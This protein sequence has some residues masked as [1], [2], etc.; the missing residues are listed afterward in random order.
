MPLT[1]SSFEGICYA[2]PSEAV[3]AYY[4]ASQPALT[5]GATSYLTEF[6]K[7][8]GIWRAK[9]WS[10][11]TTGVSTLRWNV[12]A[13]VPTFEPCDPAQNFLDGMELGWGIALCLVIASAYKLMQKA[14]K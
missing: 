1:G 2:A 7:E 4:S 11:S 14:S 9:N 8:S 13:P 3:D 10:V 12:A 5:S 6:V